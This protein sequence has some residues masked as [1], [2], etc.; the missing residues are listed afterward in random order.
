MKNVVRLPDPLSLQQNAVTWRAELLDKIDE[1]R[2]NGC[3]V[4]DKYYDKYYQKDVKDTLETMFASLCCYCEGPTGTVEF[5]HIEHRKPKKK[6]PEYTYDWDNLH[7]ACTHCNTVKGEKYSE[8]AP[9]LDAVNDII[10]DHMTYEVKPTGV[11]VKPLTLRGQTTEQHT[12]LNRSKLREYRLNT[13]LEVIGL[14]MKICQNRN[15]PG[16]PVVMAQ[17]DAMCNGLYGS[18][19]RFA[20]E[21]LLA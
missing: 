4:P 10:F 6:Y 21:Q 19:I 2:Q 11:W 12:R 7:L 18:V 16:V 20:K 5:G 9:I 14:I 1:C 3:E 15:A 8:A 17:L 13:F